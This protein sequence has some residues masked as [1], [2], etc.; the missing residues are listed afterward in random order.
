MANDLLPVVFRR[1][2]NGQVDNSIPQI[3]P[4]AVRRDEM[5]KIDE[6]LPALVPEVFRFQGQRPQIVDWTNVIE[7][8]G[9][10]RFYGAS[11]VTEAGTGGLYFLS[12]KGD[13]ESSS[14]HQEAGGDCY[15]TYTKTISTTGTMLDIDFD[16]TINYPC[17]VMNADAIIDLTAVYH[18][19]GANYKAT[20]TVNHVHGATETSLG[21]LTT[22]SRVG[23]TTA[24]Y[25]AY[26]ECFK[27]TLT[28]KAFA[29]GDKLR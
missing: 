3:L 19:D 6:T 18:T 24:P 21:T 14:A 15:G 1:G 20:A 27:F 28:R 17:I 4:A 29:I 13:L 7:G 12:S 8:V 22:P 11:L 25:N 10:K 9:Y 16:I 23:E 5:Q 2:D 26:R